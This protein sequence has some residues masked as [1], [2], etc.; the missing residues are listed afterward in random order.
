LSSGAG[1]DEKRIDADAGAAKECD[2]HAHARRILNRLPAPVRDCD[3]FL[4]VI[5]YP[6]LF[7]AIGETERRV[8]ADLVFRVRRRQN[9]NYELRGSSQI[10]LVRLIPAFLR[11][12]SDIGGPYFIFGQARKGRSTTT[13]PSPAAIG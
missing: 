4:V 6:K 5:D 1:L 10:A 7:A 9:F 12:K 8:L 13:E 11:Y 3:G 2:G